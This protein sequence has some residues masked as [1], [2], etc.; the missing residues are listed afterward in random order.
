VLR[1]SIL[2]GLL[3]STGCAT[4]SSGEGAESGR[5]LTRGR[6]TSGY[7]VREAAEASDTDGL[8]INLEHGVISQEA[9]Q[10][11]VMRRWNELTR[12]Y[13]EAGDSTG[14]AG[15]PVSLRFVVDAQGA[16]G[17]V[18]VTESR[19]GSFEVERCLVTVGRTVRFPRPQ[20]NA[21]ANIDYTLEFRSTGA[22][23]VIDLPPGTL[24]GELPGLYAHLGGACAGLG[25]DEVEATLYVDAA[26]RVRSAGLASSASIDD[27]PA[28]CVVAAL[29]RWTARTAAVQS[30]VGRVTVPLRGGEL[31]AHR[32][33]SPE[34]RRYSR[35][36]ATAR[37]RPRRARVR[38]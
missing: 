3:A 32:E 1:A 10:E 21:G 2:A 20:G 9:A 38:P 26:G 23:P 30:G 5:T 37:A 8:Q 4:Q 31:V 25:A 27:E 24:D 33:P 14:F 11:A 6:P 28:A 35:A 12:C 13:G 17:E 29:R 18:R 19:L 36:S 15:G 34:V 7:E 22:I 16:T